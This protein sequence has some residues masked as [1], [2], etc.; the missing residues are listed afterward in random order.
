VRA[1]IHGRLKRDVLCMPRFCP[2][3]SVCPTRGA[4]QRIVF[5]HECLRQAP[6]HL[7]PPTALSPFALE[8][9]ARL[10]RQS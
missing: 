8:T 6:P 5:A 2:Y 4:K 3:E 10:R 1:D 7:R 9:L